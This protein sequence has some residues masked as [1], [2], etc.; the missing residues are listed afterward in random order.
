MRIEGDYLRSVIFGCEDGLV[1]TTGSV[2]GIAVGAGDKS[3]VVLAGL[4]V[5]AVEAI[6]MG[7]GEFLSE[8]AVHQLEPHKHHDSPAK[9]G[10]L[11]FVSYIGAGL[12]PVLPYLLF[13]LTPAIF[14]S[15]GLALISLFLLGYVKGKLIG[16]A[17]WRSGA[18]ILVVGGLA[19]A[20]GV[21]VG[22]LLR[23]N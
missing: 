17:S 20:I 16:V 23:T 5:I 13:S 21:V 11:M 14:M 3:I 6:S 7:A 15:L 1:S 22:L 12:I 9:G 18:E 2:I 19:T 10:V 8:R 4:V